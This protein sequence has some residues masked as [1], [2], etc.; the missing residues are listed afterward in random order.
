M[1]SSSSAVLG[2]L[3]AAAAIDGITVVRIRGEFLFQMNTTSALNTGFHGAVGIGIASA[4]A[5]AAGVTAVPTPITEEFQDNWL[6]HSYFGC[7]SNNAI[8]AAGVSTS[9]GQQDGVIAAVRIPIDSKAMRKMNIGDVIYAAVE[10]TEVGTCTA[11]FTMNS[12][13]LVKQP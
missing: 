6:W 8:S 2:G 3:G 9:G 4:P 13:M 1:I 11:V 10:V 5:F 12:R 7:L